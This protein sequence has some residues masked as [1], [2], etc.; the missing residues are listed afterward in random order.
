MKRKNNTEWSHLGDLIDKIIQDV[1]PGPDSEMLGIWK[2]WERAVG[3]AVASHAKPKAFRGGLLIVTV[4]G[5]AWAQ[6]L[7][8][9]KAVLIKGI[10]DTLGKALINDIRFKKAGQA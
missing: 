6:Q 7:Q 9:Q 2:V 4:A 8:F 10:N 1:R 3:E 5:A